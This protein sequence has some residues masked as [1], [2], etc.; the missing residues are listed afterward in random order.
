MNKIII[1]FLSW[2]GGWRWWKVEPYQFGLSR[3]QF[4]R[5]LFLRNTKSRPLLPLT[6]DVTYIL[7]HNDIMSQ[8]VVIGIKCVYWIGYYV[9]GLNLRIAITYPTAPARTLWT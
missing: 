8:N 6:E 5:E 4:D 9:Y 3:Q 2:E 1:L 7:G